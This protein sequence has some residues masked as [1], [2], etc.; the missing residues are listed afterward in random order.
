MKLYTVPRNSRIKFDGKEFNFHHTDGAY[1]Y[2]T[3]DNGDVYHISAVAEV[4]IIKSL[5]LI[6]GEK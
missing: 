6:E 4:E 5:P 1:S 3:D 2:C